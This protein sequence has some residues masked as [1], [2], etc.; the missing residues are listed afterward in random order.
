MRGGKFEQTK[1]EMKVEL[2]P[3]AIA[4]TSE[5]GASFSSV[6]SGFS[7]K[8]VLLLSFFVRALILSPF[9]G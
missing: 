4:V 6:R 3:V 2:E 1:R 7:Q 5:V 9:R 8:S